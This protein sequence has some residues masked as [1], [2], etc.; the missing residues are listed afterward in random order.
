MAVPSNTILTSK[1]SFIEFKHLKFLIMDAPKDSNLHLYLKECERHHVSDIVRISEPTYSR[2]EVEKAGIRLHEM[3]FDD[4]ASPPQEI[5]DEWNA[6]VNEV[7][8]RRNEENKC[9]A[10]HCVAG[11]GRAPVLVAIALVENG[12]D[13][14][15]AVTLI[16]EKRRGAINAVQLAYLENYQVSGKKKCTIM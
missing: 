12:L 10:V 4:G 15:S 2:E 16:R 7:F 8:G 14:M 3:H 11:L 1:P 5:I 9:I 13:S 6:L